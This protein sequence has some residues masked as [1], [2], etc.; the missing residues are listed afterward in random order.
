[1][2]P[3]PSNPRGG[4]REGKG[5]YTKKM[6]RRGKK[7]NFVIPLD[8]QG[9]MG[10]RRVA[11]AFSGGGKGGRQTTVNQIKGREKKKK[12]GGIK[13]YILNSQWEGGENEQN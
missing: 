13:R 1:L 10:K 8:C 12:E 5:N 9:G 7:G 4:G 6:K 11:Y 3:G 2:L